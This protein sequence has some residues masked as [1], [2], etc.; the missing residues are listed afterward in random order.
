V[1]MRSSLVLLAVLAACSDSSGPH[2]IPALTTQL[3]ASVVRMNGQLGVALNA[4]NPTDTALYLSFTEPPVY[5]EIKLDGQWNA[6][7]G[8][9][10]VGQV[11]IDTLSLASGAAATLGTVN[12]TFYPPSGQSR[13][14]PDTQTD[15]Q[16]FTIAA[17]T[18]SIRACYFPWG[19][20]TPPGGIAHAQCGN[21]LSFTLTS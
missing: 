14:A 13:Q 7:G 9:G 6:G 3:S 1:Y 16:S 11:Q 20:V 12:V 10:F 19:S 8:D 17:G 5:A 2:Q 15:N 21:G 4:S 18:Y